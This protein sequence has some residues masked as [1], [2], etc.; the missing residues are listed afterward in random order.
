M[1][2]WLPLAF[3]MRGSLCNHGYTALRKERLPQIAW[4]RFP[5]GRESAPPN[6]R[7]SGQPTLSM[8]SSR[9]LRSRAAFPLTCRR[10]VVGTKSGAHRPRLKRGGPRA[11]ACTSAQEHHVVTPPVRDELAPFHQSPT[12]RRIPFT[13]RIWEHATCALQL[14][15]PARC[16]QT[17]Q[18]F[19]RTMLRGIDK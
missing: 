13:V 16:P 3:S 6:P 1:S 15:P 5:Q 12:R 8:P 14:K 4:T 17:Q 18:D 7:R 19:P 9:R 11:L 10:R 2:R